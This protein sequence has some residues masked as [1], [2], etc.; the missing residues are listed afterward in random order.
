[1]TRLKTLNSL[2]LDEGNNNSRLTHMEEKDEVEEG[3]VFF[4]LLT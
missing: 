4:T 2:S 1:M 3:W